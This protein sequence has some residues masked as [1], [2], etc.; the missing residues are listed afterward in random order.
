MVKFTTSIATLFITLSLM[1]SSSLADVNE[2][3]DTVWRGNSEEEKNAV[4]DHFRRISLEL[5]VY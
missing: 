1:T 2:F 4:L 3:K 5:F